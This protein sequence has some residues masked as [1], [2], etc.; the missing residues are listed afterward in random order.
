MCDLNK[1]FNQRNI[2]F[3]MCNVSIQMHQL[4]YLPSALESGNF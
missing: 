3:Q 2:L 4:M 1:D